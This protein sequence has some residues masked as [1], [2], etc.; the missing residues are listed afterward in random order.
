MENVSGMVKG[1]MKLIFADILRELKASGYQVSARLLNAM[2]FNV[3]QSR[4][5][6]IFIG[7]R[8]DLGIAPSHPVAESVPVTVG[9]TMQTGI[10]SDL[11]GDDS[12]RWQCIS[13]GGNFEDLPL[14][15]RTSARFSN[16]FRKLHTHKPCYTLPKQDGNMT[17]GRFFH[18]TE[19]RRIS[20]SEVKL[21]GSFPDCYKFAKQG[22]LLG[23]RI[24]NSVPPLFMRSIARHIRQEILSKCDAFPGIEIEQL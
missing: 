11:N 16:A 13:Q 17:T 3:P 4:E 6:K 23:E 20:D 9:D 15:L 24:G 8:N 19:Q 7:V 12:R 14:E 5:R 21:F 2:Y 1:K 10:P 18:P 22:K